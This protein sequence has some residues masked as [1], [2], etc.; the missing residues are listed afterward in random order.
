MSRAQARPAVAGTMNAFKAFST[1]MRK[2][3]NRG[4]R[5]SAASREMAKRSFQSKVCRF[6]YTPHAHQQLLRLPQQPYTPA[7]TPGIG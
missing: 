6:L 5:A 1:C 2:P 4:R 3:S 7:C